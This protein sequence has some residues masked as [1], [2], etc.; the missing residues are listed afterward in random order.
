MAGHHL[1]DHRAHGSTCLDRVSPAAPP[2]T[3]GLSVQVELRTVREADGSF[4]GISTASVP[5][6]FGGMRNS[7]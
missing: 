5:H 6:I 1:G 4:T 3:D 2:D 7:Q